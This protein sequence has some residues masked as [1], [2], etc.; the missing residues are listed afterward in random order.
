MRLR[1]RYHLPLLL[2]L[3]PLIHAQQNLVIPQIADG[4]GWQTTIVITNTYS[5]AGSVSLT[6]FQDTSNGNTM[7]W[8]PPF[9]ETVNLQNIGVGPSGTVFLHTMASAPI[10]TSGYAVLTGPSTITAYAIFT[11][12]NQDGTAEATPATNDILVPFDNTNGFVTSVGIANPTAQSVNFAVGMQ[13]SGGGASSQLTAIQLPPGGHKAFALPIQFPTS[14]AQ[15]GLIEF[16]TSTGSISELALRFNPTGAFTTA[17]VYPQPAG[18]IIGGGGATL[19]QYNSISI[20]PQIATTNTTG[21][22]LLFINI[23]G[24]QTNGTY[25]SA[26]VG[27][28]APGGIS[29]SAIWTNITVNGDTLTFS[30]FQSGQSTMQQSG[31]LAPITSATLTVTL[32]P[33]AGFPNNGSVTGSFNMVS[34]LATWSGTFTGAY[35]AK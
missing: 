21:L 26:T 11:Q 30:G 23:S 19:P 6:F 29:G 4:G 2:L 12:L 17:P 9:I 35:T 14:A 1:L 20:G 18:P 8:T 32:T 10:T 7:A 5:G 16:S 3:P 28:Q 24:L 27:A 15:K 25:A 34:T 31:N 13:L 22:A 33:Q